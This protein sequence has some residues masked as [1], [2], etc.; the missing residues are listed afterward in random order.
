MIKSWQSFTLG[1]AAMA[2]VFG[3]VLSLIDGPEANAA[4]HRAWAYIDGRGVL[5][6]TSGRVIPG[7]NLKPYLSAMKIATDK[8]AID[9]VTSDNRIEVLEGNWPYKGFVSVEWA[10]SVEIAQD[11]WNSEEHKEAERLREGLIDVDFA[12]AISDRKPQ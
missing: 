2:A 6:V 9:P 5:I 10:P 3:V 8:F 7:S 12:I 4:N 11:F 1:M